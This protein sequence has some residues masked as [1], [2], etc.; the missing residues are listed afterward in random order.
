MQL[1]DILLSKVSWAQ[2]RQKTYVFSHM[3]KIDPKDKY[4][5]KNKH[6]HVQIYMLNMFVIV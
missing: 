3:E 6:D 2:E 4:I 1:E 5:N